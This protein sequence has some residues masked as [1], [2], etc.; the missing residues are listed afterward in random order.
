MIS[1][2]AINNSFCIYTI[3]H[4]IIPL[5]QHGLTFPVN[6]PQNVSVDANI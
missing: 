1:V 2:S 3:K 4:W 6:T 5:L